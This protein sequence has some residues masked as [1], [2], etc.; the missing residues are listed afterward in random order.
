MTT[1]ERLEQMLATD[2]RDPGCAETLELIHAYAQVVVDGGDPEVAMPGIT[3][4]LSTS[5]PCAEDYLGLLAALRAEVDGAGGV[6][7]ET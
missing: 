3:L 2:A 1:W 4:H 6:T 5:G 7:E